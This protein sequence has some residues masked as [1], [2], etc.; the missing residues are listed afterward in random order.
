MSG[1]DG[2]RKKTR[3]SGRRPDNTLTGAF[4]GPVAPRKRVESRCGGLH[5]I[6]LF[7]KY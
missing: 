5:D 6:I 4:P 7:V 2:S 1:C 3:G